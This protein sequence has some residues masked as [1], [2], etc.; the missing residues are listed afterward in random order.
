[1]ADFEIAGVNYRTTKMGLLDAL[2]VARKIAPV[3]GRIMLV[4]GEM[5]TL[6][7]GINREQNARLVD[8]DAAAAPTMTGELFQKIL[9]ASDRLLM[10]ILEEF[11][12]MPREDVDSIMGLCLGVC[13]REQPT[14]WAPVWNVQ[15]RAP[16][17]HDI[18]LPVSLR[19]VWNVVGEQL[20]P[21][22]NAP[23][24]SLT[25][26]PAAGTGTGVSRQ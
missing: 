23:V 8:G 1:M 3:Y 21:F 5:S 24:S 17:F 11:A 15:A 18:D 12:G 19:L 25:G 14:G 13:S 9:A 20:A 22:F 10:P 4:R 7:D 6:L 26:A 16:Q 2:Q